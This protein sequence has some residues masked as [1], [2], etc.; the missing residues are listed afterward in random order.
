VPQRNKGAFVVFGLCAVGCLGVMLFLAVVY[1]TGTKATAYVDH[2]TGTSRAGISCTGTWQRDG[3]T[4]HGTI[5]GAGG[6]DLFERIDV[7]LVG[8]RAYKR[9]TETMILLAIFGAL[10]GATT[11]KIKRGTT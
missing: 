7:R 9:D 8:A 2:C 1:F 10:F 3:R 11:I 5:D 6:S 4:V